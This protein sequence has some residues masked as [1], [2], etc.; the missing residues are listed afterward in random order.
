[1]LRNQIESWVNAKIFYPNQLSDAYSLF[2][3]ETNAKVSKTH[4]NN[5][6]SNLTRIQKIKT[7]GIYT[8]SK[9]LVE[10]IVQRS[11]YGVSMMN[12]VS[13]DEKPIIINNL[14]QKSVRI[15]KKHR[16][17]M[18]SNKIK[19]F[20]LLDNLNNLYLLCA[21]TFNGVFLYHISDTPITTTIFNAFLLKLSNLINYES[22]GRFVLIDNA[23]FHGIEEIVQNAM[24]FK[25][26]AITRTPPLGCLFNPI[27]EF[28]AYFDYIL[29]REIKKFLQK[30]NQLLT[31][32][33]FID[34]IHKSIRMTTEIDFK[35]IFRRAGLL[36]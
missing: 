19:S 12:T 8:R 15:S 14:K 27:E 7:G 21:I 16:G 22:N 23:S 2:I 29:R 18:P 26:L 31:Q 34:I 17:K 28:F 25:K 13:I 1:M 3:N 20:K 36:E 6:F 32:D 4:V 9:D 33:E 35:K 10:T 24:R 11:I 5:I 30:S